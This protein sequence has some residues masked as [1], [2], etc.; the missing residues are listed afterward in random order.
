[1]CYYKDSDSSQDSRECRWKR[2][3]PDRSSNLESIPY[4]LF[5]KV[6]SYILLSC[7]QY[8]YSFLYFHIHI[9]DLIHHIFFDIHSLGWFLQFS[10]K[11]KKYHAGKNESSLNPIVKN[12]RVNNLCTTQTQIYHEHMLCNR[13][14]KVG[15]HV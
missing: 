8:Y 11:L 3:A 13:M 6:L 15:I 1:M 7:K 2:K 12:K 4:I 10:K 9:H 5:F 14:G